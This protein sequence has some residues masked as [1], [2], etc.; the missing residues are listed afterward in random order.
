MGSSV[1]SA[2]AVEPDQAAF[3]QYI[4]NNCV[5]QGKALKLSAPPSRLL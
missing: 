4:F 3:E 5:T 1:G 2:Q